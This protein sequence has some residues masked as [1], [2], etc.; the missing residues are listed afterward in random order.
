MWAS[1]APTPNLFPIRGRPPQH[2]EPGI[3]IM[4][5]TTVRLR[6]RTTPRYR[7]QDRARH[8]RFYLRPPF[9]RVVQGL[10]NREETRPA[11]DGWGIENESRAVV[12]VAIARSTELHIH[13]RCHD[14]E[15]AV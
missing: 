13:R 14:V 11:I 12:P 1:V 15:H 3:G 4:A 5:L 10:A 7:C 8:R 2:G 6:S 9:G